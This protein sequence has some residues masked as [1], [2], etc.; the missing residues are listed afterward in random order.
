MKKFKIKHAVSYFFLGLL[1]KSYRHLDGRVPSLCLCG[2]TGICS[3]QLCFT[4]A[5]G[6]SEA[7]KKAKK[8]KQG[9]AALYLGLLVCLDSTLVCSL[10]SDLS[11][12]CPCRRVL[13]W[14][15]LLSFL[16]LD[17]EL[18]TGCW[19][20]LQFMMLLI[21]VNRLVADSNDFMLF[22]QFLRQ[23]YFYLWN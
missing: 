19:V 16:L 12:S 18:K 2:I 1:R 7:P 9:T 4:A 6:V 15:F 17:K 10:I 11:S 3:S 22:L 8:T 5:Q 14:S 23:L 20:Y 21:N 13:F